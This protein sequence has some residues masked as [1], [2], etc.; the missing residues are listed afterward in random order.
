MILAC[1][2]DI[3]ALVVRD[4][5]ILCCTKKVKASNTIMRAYG[6]PFTK[7]SPITLAGVLARSRPKASI[8]FDLSRAR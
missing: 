6:M 3:E 7:S 4:A 2:G 1:N 5:I 8:S